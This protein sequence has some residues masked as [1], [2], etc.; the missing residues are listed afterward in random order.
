MFGEQQ[1]SLGNAAQ[2]LASRNKARSQ[3]TIVLNEIFKGGQPRG[4]FWMTPSPGG[5]TAYSLPW[6]FDGSVLNELWEG[7]GFHF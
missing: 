2:H 1:D 3:G 7:R 4:D 6:A 5:A